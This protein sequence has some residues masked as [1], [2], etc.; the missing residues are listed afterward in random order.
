MRISLFLQ[1][2]GFTAVRAWLHSVDGEIISQGNPIKL[3]CVNWYG[4]HK[5]L[6]V[7]GGLEQ[8]SCGFIAERIKE[9][10]A[11]CVRITLSVQMVRDNP[12]PPKWA[13]AGL[14]M[15][16]CMDT[17]ALGVLDCQIEAL[18][19]RGIMVIINIH[20]S[21]AGW[22]GA[23]EIVPQGLWHHPGYPTSD[24]IS[25]LVLMSSRY[26]DNQLVVGIDIRNEI[27]DQDNVIITWGRS[28]D[29]DSDWKAATLLADAS[30]REVNPDI[31]VIVSGLCRGYDLRSMQDL[32][33]YRS[34]FVFTTHV[35]TFSW[36]FTQVPWNYVAIFCISMLCCSV[37]GACCFGENTYRRMNKDTSSQ[38]LFICAGSVLIPI[39]GVVF[40]VAWKHVSNQ[41]GCSTIAS[42]INPVLFVSCVW[43]AVVVSVVIALFTIENIINWNYILFWFCSWNI[44]TF[45]F[46]LLAS[47]WYQSYFAVEWD[48]RKWSSPDIPVFVGEFGGAPGENTAQWGWLLHAIKDKHYSYWAVNGRRWNNIT[49]RWEPEGFGLL[50][51]DYR[52]IRDVNWT[53]TF[54]PVIAPGG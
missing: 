11:N 5:E 17:S 24:W 29:V 15:S 16:E 33:N 18:T 38:C 30:I 40:S 32:K 12:Q 51:P 36:W 23:Y 6:F 46:L 53:R 54:F 19:S 43:L 39:F 34:K 45:V 31:L 21:V 52:S 22:V 2:L 7:S 8:H 49:Y 50:T 26:R 47:I 28:L 44:V 4:A 9:I 13:I 48:L 14:N 25:S 37:C 10:G 20:N 41:V 3:R 42:D 27:H 35:Y 1:I